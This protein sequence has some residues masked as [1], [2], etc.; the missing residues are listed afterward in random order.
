VRVLI[1]A[2]TFLLFAVLAW[3]AHFLN[4]QPRR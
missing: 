4:S 2:V 1:L 3:A